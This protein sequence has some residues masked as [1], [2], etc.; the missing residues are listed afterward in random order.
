MVYFFLIKL[1]TYSIAPAFFG[2]NPACSHRLIPWLNRDLRVLMHDE[3]SHV[4]FLLQIILSLITKW[5][6]KSWF[7]G[8]LINTP[9]KYSFL[10]HI[11]SILK[12]LTPSKRL[13]ATWETLWQ[14]E[15][16]WNGFFPCETVAKNVEGYTNNVTCKHRVQMDCSG[17]WAACG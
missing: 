16:C 11:L 13:Q 3:E 10:F 12:T 15:V 8:I 4:N 17:Y 1:F 14:P 2:V 6:I 7:Q 5:V 9:K